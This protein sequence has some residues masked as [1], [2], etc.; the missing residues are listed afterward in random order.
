MT[1]DDLR[2]TVKV[3]TRPPESRKRGGSAVTMW[4]TGF[5]H[6]CPECGDLLVEFSDG[7]ELSA[8]CRK[9]GTFIV[10]VTK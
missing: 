2:V 10:E 4:L 6:E 7:R 5:A 9:H 3:L 1:A 8:Y